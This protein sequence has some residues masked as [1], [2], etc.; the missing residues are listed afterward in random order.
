MT[1]N[2]RRREPRA[3]IELRVDYRRLNAFFADYTCNISRGGTFIRTDAPLPVGTEFR[4]LLGVPG[5]PEPISLTGRV[6]WTVQPGRAPEDADPG[7]GIGF[8]FRSE[9]ERHR[10]TA[11]VEKLMVENLGRQLYDR[12]LVDHDRED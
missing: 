11:V 7:M 10:V 4:F 9:A 5:L 6:Q 12:L 2:E 8:I 1:E 3:P